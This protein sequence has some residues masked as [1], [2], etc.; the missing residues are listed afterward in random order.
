MANPRR[1]V[2]TITIGI[3]ISQGRLDMEKIMK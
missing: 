2:P 3:E 1:M